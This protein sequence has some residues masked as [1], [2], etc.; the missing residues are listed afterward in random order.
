MTI[1]KPKEF[2][3][4][5]P[6]EGVHLAV[7]KWEGQ[8]L[9]KSQYSKAPDGKVIAQL[10]VFQIEELVPGKDN[11]RFQIWRTFPDP[12]MV[13]KGGKKKTKY[14]DFIESWA[15]KSLSED[16]AEKFDSKFMLGR[17]CQINIQYDDT[18]KYANVKS[19]MPIPAGMA[20]PPFEVKWYTRTDGTD[21]KVYFQKLDAEA[22]AWFA[23]NIDAPEPHNSTSGEGEEDLPF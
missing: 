22:K 18:G 7:C 20:N 10:F 19:I 15:G 6:T 12:A 1:Y 8:T 13:S 2:D 3:N 17:A 11:M 21:E 23:A 16:A 5:L 9:Q 4:A 14:R